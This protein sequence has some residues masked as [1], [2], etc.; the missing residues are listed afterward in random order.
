MVLVGVLLLKRVRV[1]P[2]RFISIVLTLIIVHIIVGGGLSLGWQLY[3]WIGL[4]WLVSL[5]QLVYVDWLLA[6]RWWC[7][8][9]GY[10]LCLRVLVEVLCL[11]LND[12]Y[13]YTIVRKGLLFCLPLSGL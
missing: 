5:L 7:L 10:V 4:V 3:V 9:L 11:K 13:H 1:F 2:K 8:Q 6:V 12:I